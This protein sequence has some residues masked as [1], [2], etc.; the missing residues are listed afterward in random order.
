MRLQ[1]QAGAEKTTVLR[2]VAGLMQPTVG[3][4]RLGCAADRIAC[5][6]QDARLLPWRTL[7]GNVELP[8][9]LNGIARVERC[10]RAED[11]LARVGLG[12]AIDRLPRAC[13]GG[14]RMRASVAR[15]LVVETRGVAARR[16]VLARLDEVTRESLQKMLLELWK[17]DR[18]TIFL[19]THSIREAVFLAGQV[20][21]MSA[22]GEI[23][24]TI[25]VDLPK[26]NNETR[27]SQAF[28]E[29][30]RRCTDVLRAGA[31]A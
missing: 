17:S 21:V 3:T 25:E 29:F 22:T 19:V 7:R 30:V 14:M 28:N 24:E 12:D 20:S 11:A 27:T 16:T 9:E 23:A 4:V 8:L 31:R 13:S 15:A 1:D 2:L 10:A 26:R 6:F 18:M 5:C